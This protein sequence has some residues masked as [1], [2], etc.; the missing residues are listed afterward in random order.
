MIYSISRKKYSN[1]DPPKKH[2][3]C[4]TKK[5]SDLEKKYIMQRS[6]RYNNEVIYQ[7]YICLFVRIKTRA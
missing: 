5:Y 1:H 7:L 4:F 2:V 6:Y 3:T